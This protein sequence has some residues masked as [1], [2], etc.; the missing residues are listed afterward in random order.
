M[1]LRNTL[2]TQRNEKLTRKLTPAEADASAYPR[3]RHL[4]EGYR[5]WRTEQAEKVRRRQAL[6][7]YARECQRALDNPRAVLGERGIYTP[8]AEG[9]PEVYSFTIGDATSFAC[10]ET[11][12]EYQARLVDYEHRREREPEHVFAESWTF[13]I[14][15]ALGEVRWIDRDRSGARRTPAPRPAARRPTARRASKRQTGQ[16]PPDESDP[17]PARPPLAAVIPLPR[18][19][20]VSYEFACL[21][22]QG[23]GERQDDEPEGSL[24]RSAF[25]YFHGVTPDLTGPQRLALFSHLPAALQEEAWQSLAQSLEED[26]P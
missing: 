2:V 15:H 22:P 19:R 20:A 23:R 26:R 6:R 24:S 14:R 18:R 3:P 25:D 10:G 5:R 8:A 16:D 21:S 1:L 7:R 17:E 4:R 9:Q 13:P 11:A 12:A